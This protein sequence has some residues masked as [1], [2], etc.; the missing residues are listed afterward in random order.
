MKEKK[1]SVFLFV[2]TTD[3]FGKNQNANSSAA[4]NTHATRTQHAT[5]T[6]SVDCVTAET[7]VGAS[8][9]SPGGHTDN[10]AAASAVQS[11]HC[12][13]VTIGAEHLCAR[14]VLCY[15]FFFGNPIESRPPTRQCKSVTERVASAE[16]KNSTVSSSS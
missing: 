10:A 4:R 7:D 3:S 15:F 9:G 11:S 1:S 6:P 13:R 12:D 14:L 16:K 8:L 5:R 2:I